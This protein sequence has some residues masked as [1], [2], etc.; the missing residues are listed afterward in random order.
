MIF[1]LI[2]TFIILILIEVPP[3][4]RKRYFKETVVYL[5]LMVFGFTISFLQLIGIE[6]PGILGIINKVFSSA[7]NI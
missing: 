1:L 5:I 2:L 7:L 6:I 4:I 3:L